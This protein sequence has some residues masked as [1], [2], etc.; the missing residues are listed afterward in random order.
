MAGALAATLDQ[1][2]ESHR[3]GECGGEKG[4]YILRHLHGA[5]IPALGCFFP[6]NKTSLVKL[7]VYF[8]FLLNSAEVSP[9]ENIMTLWYLV[10]P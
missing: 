6:R 8:F 3:L 2:A 9:N 7:L 10:K 4:G 5:S 1:E